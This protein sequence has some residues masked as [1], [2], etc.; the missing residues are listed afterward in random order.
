MELLL[1]ILI[2]VAAVAFFGRGR[3]GGYGRGP[4]RVTTYDDPTYVEED[5]VVEEPVRRRRVIDEY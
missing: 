4:R 3:L 1:L 2:V 5:V